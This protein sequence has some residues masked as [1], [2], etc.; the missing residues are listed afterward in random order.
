MINHGELWEPHGQ[1]RHDDALEN[2]HVRQLV[3]DFKPDIVTQERVTQFEFR[4]GLL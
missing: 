2:S 3:A 4:I 1:L